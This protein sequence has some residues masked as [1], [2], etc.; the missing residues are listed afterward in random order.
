[1]ERL[2]MRKIKD[3]LRLRASG[4][5]TRRISNSLGLGRT[6]TRNYLQ[7]AAEAGLSWPDVQALDEGVL[8]RQLFHQVASAGGHPF[9]MPDWAEINREL[10][11]SGV[12][13]R[14]LW[15]EYR[16]CHPDDGYGYSAWCQHYRA[17][18]KRLSPSMRQRHVAGEKVFVDY[19]GVRMEV[20]D[21]ATGTRYPVEL[22][23]AVLGASNYT[24]AEASWSQ[25]LPDWIGAHVRA[26]EFFGGAPALIVSDNL[27]SAVVRACF[28]EPGVNRSYTDLGRH[29]HTV[30]LPARPYKPK[31]K[32][33]AEGGVLLVQ[34]WIVARLRNR[35]FFSLEEMNAAIRE[36]LTQL[37]ARVSR[38]LGASRQ[39]LFEQLDQPALIPLP[40]TRHA[41]ADW[42]KVTVGAD[43]HIRI[44]D[45]YYSVPYSLAR[46]ALWVRI[47]ASTIEAFQGGN[48]V[49]SHQRAGPQDGRDTTVKAHMPAKHRH[50][51]EMTAE[52]VRTDAQTVGPNVVTLVEVIL[53]NKPRPEQGI[54]AC[55]GILRLK[56][57]S[58]SERLDAACARALALN[59]CSL[60]S[61]TSIL[62][63]RLETQPVETAPE[64]PTIAHANIR[65]AHY[66]H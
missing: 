7:R 20:T 57:G 41:H 47:T 23:V 52:K 28:H 39:Q 18:V 37:N 66:F 42:K 64:A 53:R 6:S 26:F 43:Y 25:T 40:P 9:V 54:R 30:I 44:D 22:F 10:K 56:R 3:V 63:N 32:S 45:H 1:M 16:V 29:Y 65:G 61:V 55:V 2:P 48:R 35:A 46:A 17:W 50:Y 33:K 58:G 21:P 13:L 8:E 24:Y 27:K 60:K 51:A 11:R 62:K 49:A 5:S 19:S 38:H 12:T 4:Y 14:L 59:A 31:D 36:E 15:E 34:R